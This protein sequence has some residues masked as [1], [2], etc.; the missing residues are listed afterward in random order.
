MKINGLPVW[1]ILV[2]SVVFWLIGGV[3]YGALFT[4]IWIKAE[5]IT[6]ELIEAAE[7]DPMGGAWMFGGFL[8]CVAMV[9]GLAF[10][11]KWRGWP[12]LSGAIGTALV[13]WA[14]FAVALLG[15]DLIYVPR[16]DWAGFFVDISYNLIGWVISAIILTLMR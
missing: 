6:P 11:L 2:A 4:D 10:V 14:C 3:F 16:H 15:Y 5:G 8:L 13:L 1:G 7:A 12:D 9:K